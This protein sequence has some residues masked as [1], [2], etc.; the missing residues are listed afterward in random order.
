VEIRPLAD[1]S[2]YRACEALQ[3]E[4]WGEAFTELAPA[5]LLKIAQHVGGVTSGAFDETGALAGFV[6]GLTGLEDGRPV[7][8]SHMLAVRETHRGRGLGRALKRHQRERLVAADIR[9]CYWTYDPIMSSNAHLNLN[10]FL[11]RVDRY[12]VDMYGE[13]GSHLHEGLGTDRFVVVWPLDESAPDPF[14]AADPER[15]LR[16]AEL[17]RFTAAP[18]ANPGGAEDTP[19]PDGPAVRVAIPADVLAVRHRD[20]GAAR[21]WR[22]STRRAFRHYLGAGYRVAGYV[23]PAPGD[24]EGHYVVL[25][26]EP[27]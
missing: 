2:E 20:P 8:W 11:A 9:T 23:P 12:V 1:W 25:P 7:H 15:A 27:P 10:H 17:G 24:P 21:R 3:R 16:E 5:S 4:V 13:T 18:L 22:T 26:G 6:Y 14:D 19:L